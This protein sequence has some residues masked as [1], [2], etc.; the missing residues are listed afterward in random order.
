MKLTRA[1]DIAINVLI[2]LTSKKKRMNAKELA[3]ELCVPFNHLQKII[4]RLNRGG[5]IRTVRGKG[6]GIL[7][8]KQPDQISM[9]DVIRHIEGPISLSDCTSDDRYCY[10]HKKKCN[11][12]N[13]IEK[14]QKQ[15]IDTFKN[16]TITELTM[17]KDI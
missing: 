15:M 7:L 9:Y 3:R 8:I 14:A 17:H 2:V 4:Q 13:V 12:Q 6:G 10:H 1:A 11:V 16:T 5:I